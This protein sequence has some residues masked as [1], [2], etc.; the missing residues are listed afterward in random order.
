M[1]EFTHV[2]NLSWL[3]LAFAGAALICQGVVAQAA[4]QP[5]LEQDEPLGLQRGAQLGTERPLA[6]Q[7]RPEDAQGGRA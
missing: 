3:I 4:A 1:T 5:L 7:Q 6:Q 2:K